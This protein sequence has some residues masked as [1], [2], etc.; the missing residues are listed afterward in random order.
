MGTASL[1]NPVDQTPISVTATA[2][3][4]TISYGLKSVE[5]FNGDSADCYFGCIDTLTSVRGGVI[6]AGQSKS[7][8]SIPS[9]WKISFVCAAG[10]STTLRRVDYQ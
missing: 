2:Q 9:G 1:G 6:Y 5:F 8:E 4:I 10:K 3:E 7:F